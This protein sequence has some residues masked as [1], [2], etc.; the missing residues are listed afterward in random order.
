ML[1]SGITQMST[2]TLKFILGLMVATT[3][4]AC[5][6][7]SGSSSDGGNGGPPP[8]DGLV[9]VDPLLASNGASTSIATSLN[10]IGCQ[11]N[12]PNAVIDGTV[13]TAARISV[14]LA[15]L[16]GTASLTVNS[17]SGASQPAPSR[18][19]FILRTPQ[20]ALL[21][22]NLLGA[23]TLSTLAGGE[24]QENNV[25]FS[26]LDLDLLGIVD[27]GLAGSPDGLSAIVIEATQ[28]F[29][30]IRLQLFSLLGLVINVD[31]AGACRNFELV[32]G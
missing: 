3:L 23:L 10:C 25:Q 26:L 17:G 24:V 14:P 22:L 8:I 19:G 18:P 21:E 12:N 20:T 15:L 9:C 5:S 29:D 2:L 31:V 13:A 28:P 7:N 6:A 4:A 16:G 30:A 32:S 27:L 11:V 1:L